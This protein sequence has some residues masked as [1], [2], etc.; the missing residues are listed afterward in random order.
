[1]NTQELAE[2][3]SHLKGYNVVEVD[4][5]V[6]SFTTDKKCVYGFDLTKDGLLKHNSIK[7]LW[8]ASNFED[9]SY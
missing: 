6:N 2:T 3:V 9:C 5:I 7:F 8:M 4:W 1:M